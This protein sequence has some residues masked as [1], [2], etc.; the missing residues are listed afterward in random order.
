M[1]G[2]A[3]ENKHARR[4]HCSICNARVQTDNGAALIYACSSSAVCLGTALNVDWVTFDRCNG[5]V[6]PS[7]LTRHRETA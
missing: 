6:R 7:R 4:A 5:W 1:L 2:I 3:P